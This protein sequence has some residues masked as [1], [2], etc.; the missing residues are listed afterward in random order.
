[1]ISFSAAAP[2]LGLGV[3]DDSDIVQFDATSLGDTTA[4]GFSMFFDGS[5]V[6]LTT[7]AEDIDAFAL[8]PDGRLLISTS[9]NVSVPGASGADEDLLAFTPAAPGNYS[10]GTWALYFDGSDVGLSAESEDVDGVAVAANGDIY[11]STTGSFSVPGVS[12]ANED[13]FICT[14]TALG[15]TTA[16]TFAPVLFLDGSTVGLGGNNV[17]AIDLP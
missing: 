9:G 3:V 7:N 12:G 10:S 1:L 14:P 16:C 8:L 4:G 11:L 5:A 17:D 6:G 13:V 2:I 15:T